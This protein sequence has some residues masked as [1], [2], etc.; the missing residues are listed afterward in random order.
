MNTTGKTPFVIVAALGVTGLFIFFYILSIGR[1]IIL[2][3]IYAAIMAVLLNPLV[4]RLTRRRV[5][6]VLA[7]CMAVILLLLIFFGL[8]YFVI[9]QSLRFGDSLPVLQQKINVLLQHFSEWVSKTFR[10]SSE[11]VDRWIVDTENKQL[12]ASAAIISRPPMC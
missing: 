3:V 2:P 8:M 10:V 12:N 11:D 5:N 1:D 4:N 6:R 7:I 9:D